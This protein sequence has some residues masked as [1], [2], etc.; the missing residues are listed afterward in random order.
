[1]VRKLKSLAKSEENPMVEA[2]RESLHQIWLAGLGAFAKAR[3]EGGDAIARLVQEGVDLQKQ[4]RRGSG[5]RGFGVA[6]VVTRLSEDVGKQA[7]GS[8]EKFE[9]IFEDRVSR[10]LRSL[11]VPTQDDIRALSWQI[12]EL[13][14]AITALT[15]KETALVKRAKPAVPKKRIA[16]AAGKLA[17]KRVAKRPAI[18]GAARVAS[19][20][21]ASSAAS[22]N[23]LT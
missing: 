10:A 18:K 5:E 19:Q 7:A 13:D 9:K 21:R 12:D 6:D 15:G 17:T 23:P 4:V 11:G 14:R 20:R 8:W 3:E 1:M 16:T 22:Q 2:L